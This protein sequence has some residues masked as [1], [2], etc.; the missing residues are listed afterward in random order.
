MSFCLPSFSF[1]SI[2][3]SDSE[4][5]VLYNIAQSVPILVLRGLF[6]IL[7]LALMFGAH[8][9]LGRVD[10]LHHVCQHF[11]IFSLNTMMFN[12]L[13]TLLPFLTFVLLCYC[14]LLLDSVICGRL[15][16]LSG[17]TTSHGGNFFR[18]TCAVKICHALACTRSSK[19]DGQRRTHPWPR[20]RIA[21]TAS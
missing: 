18:M 5:L 17:Q 1:S 3:E 21:P 13:R 8:I 19:D 20:A 9:A 2:Y 14:M 10:F 16:F 4:V 12:F 11:P 15:P 6:R 7:S